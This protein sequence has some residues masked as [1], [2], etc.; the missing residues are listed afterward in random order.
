M[1]QDTTTL[2]RADIEALPGYEKHSTGQ[3]TA[4]LCPFCGMGKDRF[5]FWPEKGNW[6]CRH[7]EAKG[8][9]SDANVLTIDREEY[10]KWQAAETERKRQEEQKRLSTLELLARSGK[11]RIYHDQMKDRSYWYGQGLIDETIDYFELGYCPSCPTSP[12]SASYTIPITYQGKLYNLRHRL[13]NPN[14][15]GKYRPEMAGLPAC[16]FNADALHNQ[17][18][19][20][21]LVEGEVKA[22]VLEQY[23]FNAVGIPGASAFKEKWVKLFSTNQI[24]YVALDPGAE[25]QALSIGQSLKGNG[26][27]VRIVHLPVKPDD[28]LVVYKGTPAELMKFLKLGEAI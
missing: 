3:W 4:A 11:A 6:W 10:L 15:S 9:I 7:C 18:W 22:M 25:E 5:C 24:I 1:I 21:V 2:T 27:Q 19:M 17:E 20:T 28:F 8:F 16:M 12:Y 14:G 13:T 23:G 26:I